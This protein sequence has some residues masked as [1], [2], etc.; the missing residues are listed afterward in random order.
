MPIK[1]NHLYPLRWWYRATIANSAPI[2]QVVEVAAPQL[3]SAT[4]PPAKET[5]SIASKK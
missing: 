3:I 2:E 5:L 1:G 4:A